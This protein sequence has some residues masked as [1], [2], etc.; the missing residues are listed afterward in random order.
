MVEN[1]TRGEQLFEETKGRDPASAIDN[2]LKDKFKGAIQSVRDLFLKPWIRSGAAPDGAKVKAP[3]ALLPAVFSAQKLNLKSANQILA[4]ILA[5]LVALTGYVAFGKKPNVASI[6]TAVSERK[7]QDIEDKTI[8][9]FEKLSFYLKQIKKRN[10][11]NEFEEPKPPPPVIKPV[12]PPLPPPPPKVTIEE[13]AKDLKLM[14][15]SWGS[16]PK[17]I[18][19]DMKTQEVYFLKE[20]E[21]VEGTEIIVENILRNEVVI[22][23]D[24]EKMSML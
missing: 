15:I 3:A 9:P 8:E 5:G 4:L 14:G 6:A 16:D 1:K 17:V 11:F 23:S 24:D 2:S 13:K 18:I 22:S 10:I 20:G 12:E 7:F 19:K 21:M